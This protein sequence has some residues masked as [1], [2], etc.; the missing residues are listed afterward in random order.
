MVWHRHGQRAARE[1]FLHY[2][3]AAAPS[4]FNKTMPGKYLA[5][6]APEMTGSLGN[7]DLDPRHVNF[8]A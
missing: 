4:N 3:M 2:D 7:S 8:V 6:F 5:G 1:D